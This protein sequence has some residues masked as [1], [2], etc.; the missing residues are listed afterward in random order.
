M[1]DSLIQIRTTGNSAAVNGSIKFTVVG[2]LII[3]SLS[4]VY[5]ETGRRDWGGFLGIERLRDYLP[6]RCFMTGA[7]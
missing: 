5:S 2:L 3:Y 7:F 6:E 1:A 4:T